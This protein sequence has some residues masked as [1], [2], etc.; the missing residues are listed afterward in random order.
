MSFL[1]RGRSVPTA[2]VNAPPG[3]DMGN[4]AQQMFPIQM[5]DGLAGFQASVQGRVSLTLLA[6]LIG[7]AVI[8]YLWT[9]DAQGS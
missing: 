2:Q 5:S 8:F 4:S 7:G 3:S 1:N 9:R 6:G